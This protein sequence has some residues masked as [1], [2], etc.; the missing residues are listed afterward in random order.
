[1]SDKQKA[2]NEAVIKK[3]DDLETIIRSEVAEMRRLV[4]DTMQTVGV[5]SGRVEEQSKRIDD[6]ARH[7]PQV[8]GVRPKGAERE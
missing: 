5:V 3:I 8:V 4:M 2:S 1:M 6:L 7:V